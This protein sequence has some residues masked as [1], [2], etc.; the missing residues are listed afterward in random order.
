VQGRECK[1]LLIEFFKL[2]E[3]ITQ[4][5]EFNNLPKKTKHGWKQRNGRPFG[6]LTVHRGVHW[7]KSVV[8]ADRL[9]GAAEQKKI[10]SRPLGR[11]SKMWFLART[12]SG[13]LLDR[14]VRAQT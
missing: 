2:I 7:E 14:P 9:E 10:V 8:A 4:S 11:P 3:E 5:L 6:Q 12:T 13:W 1:I